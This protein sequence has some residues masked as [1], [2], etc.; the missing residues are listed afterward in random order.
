MLE[1]MDRT[2]TPTLMGAPITITEAEAQPTLPLPAS[3]RLLA[4]AMAALAAEERNEILD[5]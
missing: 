1:G 5:A 3:S 2:T 4:M